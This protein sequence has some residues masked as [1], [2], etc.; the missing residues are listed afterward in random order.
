MNTN[1]LLL[2]Q[3]NGQ[4]FIPLQQVCTDYFTHLSPAMLERKVLEGK[5]KLPITRIE[6]S[7]KAPRGVHIADLANYIDAQRAAALKECEQLHRRRA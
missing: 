7:N 2:A 6:A 5:I 3:Y 1:F 4:L